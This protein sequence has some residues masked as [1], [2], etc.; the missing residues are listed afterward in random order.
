MCI[1]TKQQQQIDLPLLSTVVQ[2]EWKLWLVKPPPPPSLCPDWLAVKHESFCDL[3]T[4]T[5][6]AAIAT[7]LQ[8]VLVI[9]GR[10]S[11][12]V[13][14]VCVSRVGIGRLQR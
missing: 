7:V 3:Q 8:L 11:P 14:A 12:G 4:I 10:V 9:G 2:T 1:K 13:Y 6:S 5:A